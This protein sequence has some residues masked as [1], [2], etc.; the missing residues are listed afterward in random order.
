M[1]EY[2][3]TFCPVCGNADVPEAFRFEES[4]APFSDSPRPLAVGVC[5]ECGFVC[6]VSAWEPGYDEYMD[7]A[8]RAYDAEELFDFP[9][10][11]PENVRA[12]DMIA[13]HLD[14]MD[15]MDILEIGSNRGDLL[16]MLKERFSEANVLG[17][18]PSASAGGHVPT[19]RDYFRPELFASKFDAILLK[20]VLEHFKNPRSFL[21]GVASLLKEDGILYLDVPNVRQI[22]E[23]RTDGF[24]LEHVLYFTMETLDRV[25]PGLEIVGA[26]EE[27]SLCVICKPGTA[28]LESDTVDD[29]DALFG[30]IRE[31]GS[32]RRELKN[33]LAAL[34]GRG[35]AV[36]FYGCY[37]VFRMLYRELS[38]LLVRENCYYFDD[39]YAGAS[40]P[41]FGLPRRERFTDN[42]VVVLCSNNSQALAAMEEKARQRGGIILRPWLSLGGP[43]EE[44][45]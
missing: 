18:D 15:A 40:E 34:A 36:V 42:D 25:L 41:V 7:A 43:G 12:T 30:A 26:I 13:E 28:R 44:E 31:F 5:R 19:I 10:R 14:G 11:S 33:R 3:N 1:Q 38:P 24:I 22:V 35:H 16:Y 20:Q 2:G 23:N 29:A 32:K 45:A 9:R 39:T 21:R 8:Y 4:W 27:A 17:I 6:Q 37:N